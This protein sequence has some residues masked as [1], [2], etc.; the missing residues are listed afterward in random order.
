MPRPAL[1]VVKAT[2]APSLEAAFNAWYDTRSAAEAAQVPGLLAMRRYAP[3]TLDVEAASGPAAEDTTVV[4]A[5]SGKY[6]LVT[7]A[8]LEEAGSKFEDVCKIVIYVTDRAYRE[9]VYRVVG[10]TVSGGGA[11]SATANAG[12]D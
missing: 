3:V 4:E 2:I 5:P 1:F 9:A 10:N 6:L 11:A 7:R 8:L 12:P